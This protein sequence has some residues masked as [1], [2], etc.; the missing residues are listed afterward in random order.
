MKR[1]FLISL[2]FIVLGLTACH[3]E[4]LA[5]DRLPWVSDTPVL[6]KDDFSH[7]SGGWSTHSNSSSFS[8]YDQNG[9]LLSTEI[10][11]YQF[12]SVPGLIFQDVLI[13]TKAIKLDGPEDNLFGVICRYQDPRHFYALVIGSDGYYGIFKMVNGHF[14]LIERPAMDFSAMIHPGAEMNEIHG[15]CQGERLELIV[16][17]VKLIEVQDASLTT[18]DVGLIA[19]NL[20]DPGI[21]VLFDNFFVAKP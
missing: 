1:L 20:D 11:N 12:W 8:G 19:G 3:E 18:G 15:L 9:F 13:H 10:P 2:V 4:N 7:T 6:F 5:A 16:N 17:G 21:S 14:E